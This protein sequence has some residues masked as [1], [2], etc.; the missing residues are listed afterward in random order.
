M[1]QKLKDLALRIQGEKKM[2]VIAG[3]VVISLVALFVLP[4]SPNRANRR[5]VKQVEK[6]PSLKSD[7]A[8]TDLINRLTPDLDQ[9]KAEIARL[10]DEL[11]RTNEQ[12]KDNSE[13]TAEIFKKLLEKMQQQ[14]SQTMPVG[15]DSA[16][17]VEA[18]PGDSGGFGTAEMEQFGPQDQQDVS[19]PKKA[20]L[21]KIAF[22]GAGDS[23]RVRLLAG[24]NAPTDGTPYPV[25]M[26][27]TSDIYGPDGSALPLG[28]ARLIAAAQGSI[29]DARALFRLTSLNLRMPDGRR[30]V[31][32]VDGWVVGEDGVRGMAGVLIDPLGKAIGGVMMAGAVQGFG[33]GLEVANSTVTDNSYLGITS[34]E[35]TGS[36]WEYAAGRAIREGGNEWSSIIRERVRSMVPVVQVLSGRDATAVFARS[37]SIPSLYE[38]LANGDESLE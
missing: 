28:E 20:E 10:R 21:E 29:T 15:A 30:V 33:S 9:Q 12:I 38:A 25:V 34:V 37:V 26:K 32:R 27:L 22:V 16:P 36:P 2:K 3:I 19:P 35:V 7:E 1:M 23:V 5:P 13:R 31:K 11:G 18:I 14:Q 4:S 24:V 8:Y 6:A 17:P